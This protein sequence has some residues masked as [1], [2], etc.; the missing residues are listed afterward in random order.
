MIASPSTTHPN[1]AAQQLTGRDYVSFSALALYQ[2]CPLAYKF[3]Y[4]DGLPEDV[5]SSSLAFGSGIHASVEYHFNE[6]LA[7]NPA[8]DH[9]TLL[10]A[11]WESWRGRDQEASIRFSKAE[12]INTIGQLADRVL[13]AFRQSDLSEPRG[14]IIGVEEQL[15]GELIP[16]MPDLLA[17]IDLLVITNDA[18]VITD[19][20]T[21]RSRW[22]VGQAQDQAEQLLLYSELA[23]QL[24]PGKELRLEFAVVTK[25]KTPIAERH[26]VEIDRPRINR[27]KH[28][29]QHVWSA[30]K[31]EHF[32]P[33]PS[34][35][36]CPSCPFRQ[37]C[38]YWTG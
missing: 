3:K 29:V 8:P 25:A 35:M 37:P 11:F 6:L 24:A 21:S 26:R 38:R 12:D 33:A 2:R 10:D 5:I 20:K 22:K 18:L 14:R 7:G 15:R 1:D 17:R 32:Y 13:L 36:N 28:M 19:F 4:V 31:A 9:D 34:P 27:T 23:R 16:S 30:I